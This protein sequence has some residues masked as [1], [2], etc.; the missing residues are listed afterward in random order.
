[1]LRYSLMNT[2]QTGPVFRVSSFR[3]L[4]RKVLEREGDDVGPEL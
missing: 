1:M 3:G 2:S 4:G